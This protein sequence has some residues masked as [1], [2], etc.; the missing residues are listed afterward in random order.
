M[1][2][3][4][5]QHRNT[6]ILGFPD[7]VSIVILLNHASVGIAIKYKEKE[8]IRLYLMKSRSTKTEIEETIEELLPGTGEILTKEL[9]FGKN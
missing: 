1:F 6:D 2:A 9:I 5:N 8:K 4:V 7:A 3:Q